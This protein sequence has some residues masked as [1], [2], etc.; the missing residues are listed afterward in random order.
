VAFTYF[1][2]TLQRETLARIAAWLVPGG[3]L[4]IGRH[5]RLPDQAPGFVPW[6][7]VPSTFLRARTPD[8]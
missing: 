3:A 7:E 1:D 5:E 8:A 4:V 2:A 6:P